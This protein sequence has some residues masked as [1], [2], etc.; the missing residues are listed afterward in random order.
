MLELGVTTVTNINFINVISAK[1]LSSQLILKALNPTSENKLQLLT[2]QSDVPPELLSTA[3]DFI[4][5]LLRKSYTNG[6]KQNKRLLVLVNQ[7]GGEFRLL[8][9]V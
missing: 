1:I 5:N 9:G 8:Q 7:F 2:F 6:I 4:K 3:Q